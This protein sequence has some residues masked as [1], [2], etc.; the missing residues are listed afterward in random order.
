M[1]RLLTHVALVGLLFSCNNSQSADQQN[2]GQATT[3]QPAPAT[4][5]ELPPPLPSVPLELLQKIF[6][7]GTQID[8]IYHYHPFTASLSEKPAIQN[9][10][11]HVAETPAPIKPGCNPAGI[12]TYQINGDIVL[13]ADF[14]FDTNCTFFVFYDKDNNKY[15]NYM[16]QEGVDFFNGQ[17]QQALQ[18][19]NNM[20]Q[21]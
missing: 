17:I 18:L 21:Q 16:T 20:Q 19:R 14:Y 4:A 10:I 11:R 12:V 5:A 2:D 7:E 6:Q 13:R 9:A 1:I 3:A 8:Y 15:A